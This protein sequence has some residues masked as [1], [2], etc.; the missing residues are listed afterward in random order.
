MK[1]ETNGGLSFKLEKMKYKHQIKTLLK[2]FT[3]EHISIFDISNGYTYDFGNNYKRE[4]CIH[5]IPPFK[6]YCFHA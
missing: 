5:C 4:D 3:E 1:K 2:P 6:L